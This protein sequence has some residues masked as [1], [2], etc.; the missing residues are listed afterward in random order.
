MSQ[1]SAKRKMTRGFTIIELLVV[2]FVIG[3]LVALLLPAIG[4]SRQAARRS[5]C[6]NNL[7]QVGLA[8]HGYHELHSVLPPGLFHYIG[9]GLED[10]VQPDGSVGLE[11]AKR[12]CWMQQILPQLGYENLYNQLPFDS[13]V[14]S[15]H[16]ALLF[17]APTWTVIPVLMCPS[18]P[19]NPKLLDS[20]STSVKNAQGFHGNVALCAGNTEFG[21]GQQGTAGGDGAGDDLN[22]MFYAISSTRLADVS[23]GLSNTAMGSELILVPDVQGEVDFLDGGTR[24]R[25]EHGRY[26]NCYGGETLFSTQYGPNTKV[27]DELFHCQIAHPRV[28]CNTGV[29]LTVVYARSYHDGGVNLMMGDGSVRFVSDFVDLNVFRAIGS[30]AGGET[31]GDF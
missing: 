27:P 9:D 20:R 16:W 11:G 15:R 23:D 26:Y 6:L 24:R 17:D 1:A 28:P 3:I 21:L 22:G 31:V 14:D 4:Q 2:V 19:A 13:N 5:Q 25:D 12:S 10:V 29:E 18:D 30:R 7:K 8:L